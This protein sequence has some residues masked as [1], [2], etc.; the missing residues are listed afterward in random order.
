MNFINNKLVFKNNNGDKVLLFAISNQSEIDRSEFNEKDQ[1]GN[2]SYPDVFYVALI[3]YGGI[4]AIPSYAFIKEFMLDFDES[5]IK[6]D[7][8]ITE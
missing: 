5:D 4:N 2:K 3:P 1:F 7:S 6:L 8:K